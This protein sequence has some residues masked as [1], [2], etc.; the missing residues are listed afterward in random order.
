MLINPAENELPCHLVAVIKEIYEPAGLTITKKAIRELE[1]AEYGACRF[2]L[3]EKK[4]VFRVAK[5]TPTKIGKFVT[6]WKRPI[7]VTMPF[8]SSDPIDYIIIDVKDD[9][10]KGQFIFDRKILIEKGIIS[11][12]SRKGKRGIRVYPP[13]TMPIAKQAIKTQEWQLRYF[14]SFNSDVKQV[15]NFFN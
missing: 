8:D 14:Y 11:H 12:E 10:N 4:I 1:S 15:C 13:W 7:D 5:T 9:N 2:E 6:I 3:D